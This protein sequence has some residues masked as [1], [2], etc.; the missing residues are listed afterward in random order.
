MENDYQKFVLLGCQ[1]GYIVRSQMGKGNIEIPDGV[2]IS[3]DGYILT[4]C[5]GVYLIAAVDAD[6]DVPDDPAGDP[7]AYLYNGV[8]LP[9]LPEWD[10]EVYPYAVI[11][12]NNSDSEIY[13][14]MV[15]DE[16][17]TVGAAGDTE[18]LFP[19]ASYKHNDGEW[20]SASGQINCKAIWTN[21]DLYTTDGALSLERS[22]PV[23]VYE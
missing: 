3:S 2:L 13:S 4:D 5:N 6:P 15:D 23:P 7:V 10:R 1:L 12:Q 17:F 19:G 18:R 8:K 16:P 14:F 21:T 9:P 22:D 20:V 11:V